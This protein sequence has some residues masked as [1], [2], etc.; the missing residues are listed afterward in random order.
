M[1][2]N[3][4]NAAGASF[5]KTAKREEY[6]RT[7][8]GDCLFLCCRYFFFLRAALEAE[9][10]LSGLSP[11]FVVGTGKKMGSNNACQFCF[12]ILSPCARL[13][14]PLSPAQKEREGG[15]WEGGRDLR[16]LCSFSPPP[17][18]QGA[19]YRLHFSPALPPSLGSWM[20]RTCAEHHH[21]A[22]TLITLARSPNVVA[23]ILTASGGGTA[24]NH[25]LLA[26]ARS[27]N[28]ASVR[29][30]RRGLCMDGEN[31]QVRT[32]KFLKF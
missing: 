10:V 30:R 19:N 14:S 3:C 15:G 1:L 21:P 2:G 5:G 9:E 29:G 13:L 17:P 18:L 31:P 8:N 20:G 7:H 25:D 6:S 23:I 32:A 16:M 24:I 11:C 22:S 27:R 12:I 26:A 28:V 4:A